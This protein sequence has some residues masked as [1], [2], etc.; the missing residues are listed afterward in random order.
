M[1]A[2]HDLQKLLITSLTQTVGLGTIRERHG[3]IAAKAPDHPVPPTSQGCPPYII[4]MMEFYWKTK[5]LYPPF[6]KQLQS[7]FPGDRLLAHPYLR[8]ARE[9]IHCQKYVVEIVVVFHLDKIPKYRV[10]A[11][12]WHQQITKLRS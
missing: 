7:V 12:V 3:N 8:V 5:N 9:R 11:G 6:E 2:P 10:V 1:E 4:V